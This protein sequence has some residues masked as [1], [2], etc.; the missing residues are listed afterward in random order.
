MI[1]FWNDCGLLLNPI[2]ARRCHKP[3]CPRG[4]GLEVVA[5]V[6]NDDAP[7]SGQTKKAGH[8]RCIKRQRMRVSPLYTTDE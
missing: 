4:Q 3:Q 1:G 5:S 7:F 6:T 8:I 2:Q